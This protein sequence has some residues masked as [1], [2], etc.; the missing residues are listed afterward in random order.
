MGVSVLP[1][2][3]K[4]LTA[5]A[6]VGEVLGRGC[7]GV[8]QHSV[9]CQVGELLPGQKIGPSHPHQ[10][11]SSFGVRP[12]VSTF[13]RKYSDTAW[14]SPTGYNRPEQTT[15]SSPSFRRAISDE[16]SR[17][18]TVTVTIR[19]YSCLFRCWCI[20]LSCPTYLFTRLESLAWSQQG[21]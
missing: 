13:E 6:W 12:Y 7:G 5:S 15:H 3:R 4:Y 20:A 21:F 8:Q 11:K 18:L 16:I 2:H 17:G 1:P 9:T 10:A 14:L 19:R